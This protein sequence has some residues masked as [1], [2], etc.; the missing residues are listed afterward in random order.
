M[1]STAAPPS[2]PPA[3]TLSTPRPPAI[4]APAT[5]ATQPPER[6]LPQ[7]PA[8]P[9]PPAE[10]PVIPASPG[11]TSPRSPP[12][13]GPCSP[14]PPVRR[15]TRA[16][17]S[18]DRTRP[19]LEDQAGHPPWT[20]PP[21]DQYAAAL[22][23]DRWRTQQEAP[24]L[25]CPSSQQPP[26]TILHLG[27]SPEMRQAPGRP[28]DDH[29]LRPQDPDVRMYQPCDD[30]SITVLPLDRPPDTVTS[31]SWPLLTPARPP[32]DTHPCQ[33]PPADP[34]PALRPPGHPYL[35]AQPRQHL[36]HLLRPPEASTDSARPHNSRPP[37]DH[38]PPAPW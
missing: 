4:T 31:L 9:S 28:P 19:H 38:A 37:S 23:D 32:E 2:S 10:T 18:D 14:Q 33:Q 24:G 6:R 7:A 17:A 29:A 3:R 35:A 21:D 16:P 34:D 36:T 13:P 26:G 12:D 25:I 27:H 22:K 15:I 30:I 8:S 5:V 20:R 11:Q 1:A